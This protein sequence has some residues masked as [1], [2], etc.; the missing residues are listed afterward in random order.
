MPKFNRDPSPSRHSGSASGSGASENE[1]TPRKKN[2]KDDNEICA[3][4]T[5]RLPAY[6]RARGWKAGLKLC[7]VKRNFVYYTGDILTATFRFPVKL[8][9][10]QEGIDR[11]MV[12]HPED[13]PIQ[14]DGEPAGPEDTDHPADAP[15]EPP[16][17]P[18]VTDAAEAA[19]AVPDVTEAADAADAAEAADAADA[20]DA[21]EAVPAP[22]KRARSGSHD[23]PPLPYGSEHLPRTR[24]NAVEA[25]LEKARTRRQI[26]EVTE[27]SKNK[28]R[29]V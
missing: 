15:R 16:A 1:D 27:S 4:E 17:A 24:R 20:A 29:R 3:E 19:E 26:A 7:G 8:A 5:A 6:L 23:V 21:A 10:P 14:E 18:D 25:A 28:K 12:A 9:K 13:A 11:L 22:S 2:K